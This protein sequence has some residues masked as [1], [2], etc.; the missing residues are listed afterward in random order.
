MDKCGSNQNAIDGKCTCY[1]GFTVNGDDCVCESAKV[2]SLN[3]MKCTDTCGTNEQAGNNKQC[4]CSPT[5]TLNK[6][7]TGCE[8]TAILSLSGEECVQECP[9]GQEAVG[10]KC[11]LS[12]QSDTNKS[13]S[14]KNIG[15]ILGVVI[16]V[17]AVIA[18]IV[19]VVIVVKKKRNAKAA[20]FTNSRI[21]TLQ[22][23]SDS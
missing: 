22:P 21:N 8:C 19:A 9:A 2:I 18:I 10:N 12:A 6:E 1:S 13:S 16:G 20:G 5:F 7:E 4:Q 17:L 3:G 15:L 11:A 14:S 23:G